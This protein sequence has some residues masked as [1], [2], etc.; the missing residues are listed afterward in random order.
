M[1]PNAVRGKMQE[2]GEEMDAYQL[3]GK[4]VERMI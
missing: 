3:A 1:I 4:K 2:H